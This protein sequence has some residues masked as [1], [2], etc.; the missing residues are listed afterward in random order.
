M[1]LTFLAIYFCLFEW[2]TRELSQMFSCGKTDLIARH[3][4]TILRSRW[5]S[6]D[7]QFL[8]QMLLNIIL[9]YFTTA[10]A[11]FVASVL[12]RLYVNS[13]ENTRPPGIGTVSCPAMMDGN[14]EW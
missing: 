10:V 1:L 11:A 7:K 6:I 2:Q 12:L 8:H 4:Q 3:R 5:S 13:M 14:L 9:K